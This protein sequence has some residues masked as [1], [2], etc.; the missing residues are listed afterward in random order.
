MSLDFTGD[1]FIDHQADFYTPVLRTSRC[2]LVL[3]HRLEVPVTKWLDQALH[4]KLVLANQVVD[5]RVSTSFAQI[6]VA[7][8][9]AARV[10]VPNH[11]YDPALGVLGFYPF[12]R[13]VNRSLAL[14]PQNGT[15]DLE[16]DYNRLDGIEVIESIDAIVRRIS[17]SLRFSCILSGL[18]SNRGGLCNLSRKSLLL[19][20]LSL[21]LSVRLSFHR[22]EC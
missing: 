18:C 5:H 1:S 17:C 19:L 16:V 20:L 7:L 22:I 10:G 6:P 3:S 9:I 12:S 15:A 2:R 13:F 11:R 14:R 4:W 8:R 21:Q